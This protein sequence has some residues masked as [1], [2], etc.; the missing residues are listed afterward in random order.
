MNAERSLVKLLIY[1]GLSERG[2]CRRLDARRTSVRYQ[3]KPESALN[4]ALEEEL[5]A[6]SQK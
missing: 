4:V 3:G 5:K 2:A 1:K 6:L